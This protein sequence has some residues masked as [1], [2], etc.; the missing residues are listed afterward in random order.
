MIWGGRRSA[1]V[2]TRILI[3]VQVVASSQSEAEA[4]HAA[5][6]GPLGSQLLAQRQAPSRHVPVAVEDE[7]A[8]AALLS[9]ERTADRHVCSGEGITRRYKW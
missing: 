8:A 1:Y 7:H 5:S 6:G 3:G 9:T 4:R 2:L